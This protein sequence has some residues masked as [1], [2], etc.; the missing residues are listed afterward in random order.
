MEGWFKLYRKVVEW[1]WFDDPHMVQLFIYLLVKANSENKKWHGHEVKRGQLACSVAS[2]LAALNPK[3]A[4]RDTAL[5]TTKM[6]RNRLKR[7]EDSGTITTES[8]SKYTLITICNY[9]NYQQDEG[10]AEGK[11]RANEGQA[12]GKQRANEGQQRKNKEDYKNSSLRSEFSQASPAAHT[13]EGGAGSDGESHGVDSTGAE[14]SESAEAAEATPTAEQTKGPK[15]EAV[16]ELFNTA[17]RE[18][19]IPKIAKMTERRVGAIH[20]RVGEYGSEAIATVITK[21]AASTFLNGGGAKQFVASFD[22]IFL[23]NNFP[24]ILEG[25]YDNPPTQTPTATASPTTTPTQTTTTHGTPNGI[26]THRAAEAGRTE[27]ENEWLS[28]AMARLHEGTDHEATAD[29]FELA[30]G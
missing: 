23:P 5:L 27:R 28:H 11:Q 30:D 22:W 21:A 14:P 16:M 26:T 1:E 4:K 20:A 18:K 10:Q 8:C 29:P 13:R 19:R 3:R 7:L 24:K 2:I 17:V 12:E 25:N 6:L 15:P 9:D